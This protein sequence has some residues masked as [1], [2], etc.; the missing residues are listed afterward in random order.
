MKFK[1]QIILFFLIF[2]GVGNLRA[3]HILVPMDETQTN[4]LKAYGI[5]FWVLQQEIVAEW[6][7]NYRG[8]SF[9]FRHNVIFEKECKTRDVSFEIIPDAAFNKILSDIDNPEVNQ[10]AIK[11]E[12]APTLM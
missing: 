9:A 5:T 4:H 8:G 6:L 3:S 11:L 7:L 1:K 12:V 2:L 10:D